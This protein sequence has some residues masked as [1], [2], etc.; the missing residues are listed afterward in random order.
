M[1][2]NIFK[3]LVITAII[4]LFAFLPFPYGVIPNVIIITFLAKKHLA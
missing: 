2:K 4:T 1:Y 3:A